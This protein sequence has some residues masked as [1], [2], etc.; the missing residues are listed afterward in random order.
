MPEGPE[1]ELFRRAAE[2]LIG[3]RVRSIVGDER[4]SGPG[5]DLLVGA[6][7]VA[8][9]RHGKWVLLDTD[10]PTLGLHFGMTGRLVVDGT[11]PIERLEYGSG[12]D[13]PAWDRLEITTTDERVLRVNDPRRWSRFELDPDPGRW[14]PDVFSIDVDGLAAA[15]SGRR[16]VKAVLLDQ[17]RIAGVGNLCADEVLWHAGIDPATPARIVA[18]ER[19][20][21]LH[22]VLRREMGSLL[23]RGGS[24][25]G[26]LSPAIR[27]ELAGCPDDGEPLRRAV[28]GGRTTVWC[29]RHQR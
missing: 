17:H 26:V 24:H 13:D 4:C 28:I 14:G 12:R 15:L 2:P 22:T 20:E 18:A 5:L 25:T 11:A 8:A 21:H 10:G 23:E 27:A 19:L 16:A 7:I 9:G 29:P 1:A 6:R 3:A